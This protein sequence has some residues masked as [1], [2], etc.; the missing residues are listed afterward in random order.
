MSRHFHDEVIW[1]PTTN[2]FFFF[3][4]NMSI[5][6]RFKKDAALY[7]SRP[8]LSCLSTSSCARPPQIC[9]LK[10]FPLSR[11]LV[12]SQYKP[13][14]SWFWCV[15]MELVLVDSVGLRCSTAPDFNRN[16]SQTSQ[17]KNI[18]LFKWCIV[19]RLMFTALVFFFVKCA[20]GNFQI[21]EGVKNKWCL[22]QIVRFVAWY[23][24]ASRESLGR[25]RP[26]RR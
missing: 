14:H 3:N 25:D 7:S 26:C 4:S 18:D 13:S 11:F 22:W 23:G 8:V 10:F 17:G 21:P 5:L 1:L 24:D 19:V 15:Q 20:S 16:M 2:C 12:F 9:A 6:L